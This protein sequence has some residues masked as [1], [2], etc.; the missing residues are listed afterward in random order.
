MLLRGT[1]ESVYKGTL[2]YAREHNPRDEHDPLRA[3]VDKPIVSMGLK[4]VP[5]K[6]PDSIYFHKVENLWRTVLK[7]RYL[8]KACAQFWL[9][10]SV[11][12]YLWCLYPLPDKSQ[13]LHCQ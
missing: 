13:V 11:P 4:H 5:M 7:S 1:I 9:P 3:L 10:S 12:L 8:P 6:M 2:V